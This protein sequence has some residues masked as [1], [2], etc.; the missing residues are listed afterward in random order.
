M[1]GS[2]TNFDWNL[3]DLK[4]ILHRIYGCRVH[5][6]VTLLGKWW[7]DRIQGRIYQNAYE[8]PASNAWSISIIKINKN[9]TSHVE[10]AKYVCILI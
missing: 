7:P 2:K 9:Y 4:H 3:R 8:L 5:N 1:Y 6:T 10:A